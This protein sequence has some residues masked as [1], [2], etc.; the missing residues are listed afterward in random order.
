MT[1]VVMTIGSLIH[2]AAIYV[3]VAIDLRTGPEGPSA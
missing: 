2:I 1:L 3:I